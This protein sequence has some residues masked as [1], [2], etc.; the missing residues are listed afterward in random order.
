MEDTAEHLV[1]NVLPEVPVRQWVLSFPR[2]VR[3]LAARHPALASRLL[4]LFTRAAFTWQRRQ[5]RLRGVADPRTGGV[6]AVQRFGGAI[7]LNVHFHTL[8]PDG[9]FD[10]EGAGQPRFVPI[11]P[12]RDE[13]LVAILDRIVRRTAKALVGYD[14][15]ASEDDA[16]AALQATEVDRRLRFPDPFRN[17]RHTASLDGFSLHAGVRIHEHDREG[18]ERLC[19]YAVRPPFAL[20][21]LSQGEDG[22]LVYRMKRPRGGSLFLLLE[23]GELLARLATL[24][25]P[26]RIH[27]VRYHGIFAPNSKARARVVPGSADAP[28]PMPSPP[29]SKPKANTGTRSYRVPWADLLKK[30]F[31]VDVLACPDCGGRLQIIAFIA[32]DTVARRILLHLRLDSRGPT[33]AR[34][35]APPDF[36]ELGPRYD[37]ADPVYAD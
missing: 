7:N 10:V 30:V 29:S 19:R 13:E 33:V 22:Q 28:E 32:D 17:Q 5:A 20:Q 14:D 31:A 4:D 25:P 34:A 23:P 18:L 21:R 9:V 16:L 6:T 26:P 12:P 24:V 1:R 3:F 2:R 37:G 27:S 11:P 15:L 8:I 35:Q 36:S